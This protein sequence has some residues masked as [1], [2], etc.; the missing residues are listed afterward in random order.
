MTRVSQADTTVSFR[1]QTAPAGSYESVPLGNTV[2]RNYT[3]VGVQYDDGSTYGQPVN[4]SIGDNYIEYVEGSLNG[5]TASI[6]ESGN[7]I[8][9]FYQID[10]DGDGV[11]DSSDNCSLVS[12]AG[13]T[14]TDIDGQGDVC[15]TDDDGDE[16]PD[17]TDNCSLVSNVDQED[18]DEDGVGDYCDADGDGDGVDNDIDNC[19]WNANAD[20]AD[21]NGNGVGNVCEDDD[22]DEVM[23]SEDNCPLNSNSNQADDD[24]DGIGNVCDSSNDNTDADDDGIFDTADNCPTV[25]NADQLDGDGDGLG[26]VCDSNEDENDSDDDGVTDATD[27]CVSEANAD[28]A[29][30]DGDHIGDVCDEVFGSIPV[31]TLLGDASVDM[32]VGDTYSDAGAT[33]FDTEDGNITDNI[34]AVNGV[35]TSVAGTYYVTYNVGDS[36]ENDAA[37]VSRTVI[38]REES[39][40]GGGGSAVMLVKFNPTDASIVINGGNEKTANRDVALTLKAD[41]AVSMAISNTADFSGISWENF[42]ASKEWKLTTGNGT[43]TVYAKFK[44]AKGTDT[45]VYSDTIILDEKAGGTD[46]GGEV[47]GVS[48]V[49]IKDGDIIQCKNASDPNAVYIVKVADGKKFIRHITANG[50]KFYKH[51]K[52]SNLIQVDSLENFQISRWVRVNTGTN[53]VAAPTDKV[54]EINGDWTKHWLD[55]TKEKFYARGGSEAAVFGINQGELDSYVTGAKVSVQ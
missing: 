12:N 45:K 43:K 10:T 48:S 15:D 21:A 54:W 3:P 30:A 44:S 13:Q 17:T 34:S 24:N 4:L 37:E 55:M 51:L 33:A 19:V 47:K 6:P 29:D 25:A 7:Y 31:I 52:W 5:P 35:N 8:N 40:S 14:D 49:N 23:N 26:D 50:F 1:V 20:Q 42:S 46:D 2:T 53:G 39:S 18:M 28:Q 36:D 41:K 11:T 27:N 16:V 22:G 32:Y 38:V 9:I